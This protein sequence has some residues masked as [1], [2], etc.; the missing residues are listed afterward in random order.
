MLIIGCDYHPSVQQ[1]A[2][3]DTETGSLVS[4]DSNTVREKQRSSIA[5][6]SKQESGCECNGTCTLV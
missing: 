4:G 5:I 2:F 6:C 1:I 3:M